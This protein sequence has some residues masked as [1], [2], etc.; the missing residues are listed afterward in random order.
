M[1]G[2]SS[3]FAA[4]AVMIGAMI[5]A[6][7]LG[8]PHVASKSGFLIAAF[9]LVLLGIVIICVNLW[10]GEVVL[11]TKGDHQ[12]TGYAE[13]YLGEKGK[14]I[15][16]F[17]L[18]FGILSALVAYLIGI[19]QSVSHL[20]IQ[21]SSLSFVIAIITWAILTFLTFFGLQTF[22]LGE[23]IGLILMGIFFIGIFIYFFPNVSVENLSTYDLS[24]FFYPFGTILFALLSFSAIPELNRILSKEKKSMKRAIFL[25]SFIPIIVYL[26]FTLVLVGVKGASVPE[27]STIGLGAI[28]I[29]L[30]IITMSTSYFVLATVLKSM[31][32]FDYGLTKKVSWALISLFAI[33]LYVLTFKMNFTFTKILN[34]SGIISGSITGILIMLMVLKAKRYGNR[35]S[36][37]SLPISIPLLILISVIFILGGVLGLLDLH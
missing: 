33:I 31:L 18:V 29:F 28:F 20:I 13:K 35:K 36:E 24:N 14:S 5:G 16:F 11:R 15:I 10:M 3:L 9:H 6:G 8:I 22:K 34:A 25:G 27:V 12:L 32:H 2:K 4:V 1:V 30:G 17:M 19:S 23:V 26:L 21:N 7:F 37:Y